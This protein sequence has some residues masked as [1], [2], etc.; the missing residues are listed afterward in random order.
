MNYVFFLIK[1]LS[2]D[3]LH[4]DNTKLKL[5]SQSERCVTVCC[6]VACC[7]VSKQQSACLP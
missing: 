7:L 2:G 1:T 5:Q 3:Q 6:L 4:L